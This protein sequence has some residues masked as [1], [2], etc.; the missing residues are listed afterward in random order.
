MRSSNSPLSKIRHIRYP[1][2]SGEIV[3]V[4]TTWDTLSGK[5]A[6]AKRELHQKVLYDAA[7]NGGNYEIAQ[8][9]VKSCV[10]NE[11]WIC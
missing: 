10:S 11:F 6:D 7:K 1:W 5:D 4:C 9:I 2:N 3:R 8:S